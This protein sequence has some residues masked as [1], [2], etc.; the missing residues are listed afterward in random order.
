MYVGQRQAFKAEE[1]AEEEKQKN[2]SEGQGT[3]YGTMAHT[4]HTLKSC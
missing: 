2:T 4:G 3:V 1:T